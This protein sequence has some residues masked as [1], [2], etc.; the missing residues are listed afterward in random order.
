MTRASNFILLGCFAAVAA[1]FT[2]TN[3]SDY[4]I[5]WHLKLGE[6]VFR[7]GSA[8]HTDMF[9]YTFFGRPQFTGEWLGDLSYYLAFLASGMAGVTVLEMLLL[10]GTMGFLLLAVREVIGDDEGGLQAGVI[11]LTVVL[12]AVRFRLFPRTY[13]FSFLFLSI[14]LFCIHRFERTRNFRLL[15]LL[16]VIEL[17]WTNMS[18]GAFY[19]TLVLILFLVREIIAKRAEMKH[20]L[21]LALVVAAAFI[22]PS[23]YEV[24]MMPFRYLMETHKITDYV[25]EHQPLTLALLWGFGL[26]YTLGFQVLA[27]GALGYFIFFNGWKNIFHVLLFAFFFAQVSIMIRMIDLFSFTN[28]IAFSVVIHQ[29][30]IFTRSRLRIKPLMMTTI[31]CACLLLIIPVSVLDNP[32]YAFGLGIKEKQFPKDALAFLDR[33]GVTGK[34]FNSYHYG[35]YILWNAPSRK[36]FID[37]RGAGILYSDEFYNR[38]FAMLKDQN[39]WSMEDMTWHYD[40]AVLD[41]DLMSARFPRHL[42]D[43]PDWS[44]VYWDDHSLVYLKRTDANRAV[45]EHYGYRTAKPEFYDFNYLASSTRPARDVLH[46]LEHDIALNPG[47]QEPILAKAFYLYELGPAYHTEALHE[48]D[49]TMKLRP[50]MAIKH[51]ARAFLLMEQGKSNEAENEAKWALA[52]DPSDAGANAVMRRIKRN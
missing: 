1:C 14:F 51:S 40:Y 52:L 16:P 4:D 48:I 27:I 49:R 6:S 19:G 39:A 31:L 18:K 28:A 3:I 22:N 12:F 44:L 9:S 42:V 8:Y 41:Y 11:T 38:Y 10:L 29:V 47:N 5:W 32:T 45:I 21:V 17:I 37:G 43:N 26:Q 24:Y 2:A 36:V 13:M 7:T 30:L 20:G 35:G 34:M 23:T 33:E 25:G 15:L 46:D 50:D